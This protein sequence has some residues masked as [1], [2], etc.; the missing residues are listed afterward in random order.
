MEVS[1]LVR[2]LLLRRG[3]TEDSDIAA[4]LE[5]DYERGTH[6]PFL[7]KDMD[8]AVSRLLLAIESGERI[9]VYA[10]FDCDGIPG[11]SLFSDFLNKISYSNFEVYLPHRDREG[12]GFHAGAIEELAT[13]QVSLIITIDVGTVAFDG[14]DFAKEKGI[15]VIVT[16]H[17]EPQEQIPAAFAILNPKFAPYPYPH[18]CGAATAWKFVVATLTEGKRRGLPAFKKIPDGWEKWLLDMVAI[19]TVADMVPLIG[20]NRTL[21]HWGLQVLHRS[22]RIGLQTLLQKVR[23]RQRDLTEDDIG[24]SIAPRI[25]AAS[26]M[27]EPDLALK[28]LTTQSREEAHL[29]ATKLEGLNASRKGV[30][31]GVVREARKHVAARYTEDDVVVVVGD[32][33]WKPALLGLAANSIMNERGGVVCLWGRDANGNLKGSCRSDGS[34]AIPDLFLQ[35]GDVFSESGGHEK[36]GGFSVSPGRAHELQAVLANAAMSLTHSVDTPNR[37]SDASVLIGEI[38]NELYA[39]LTRLSPFGIENPKPLLRI[40]KCIITDVRRFGKEGAHT[41]L[42]LECRVSGKSMRAFEFF[43]AP[44]NFTYPATRGIEAEVLATLE[45]DSFRGGLALRLVDIVAPE[46]PTMV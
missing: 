3:I 24:F 27:D 29:L 6:D 26:R 40:G 33:K 38:S 20:E 42:R 18:L 39:D 36:S 4:F 19:A 35:A 16:D 34:V 32:P 37:E 12:Y 28:L 17:H 46:R 31:A 15:D 41:E 44:D 11:A 21:V 13:R 9:A 25:N 22:R 23:L 8:R 14:V 45:R 43:K 7:M 10:D 30:V 5:P 1:E 2:S